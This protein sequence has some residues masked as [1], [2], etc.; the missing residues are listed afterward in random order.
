M[1]LLNLRLVFN[2]F[3]NEITIKNNQ[4]ICTSMYYV[5][6][7]EWRGIFA[8]VVNFLWLFKIFHILLFSMLID[9]H[10]MKKW[11]KKGTRYMGCKDIF[12]S[13]IKNE[14]IIT[15]GA[16]PPWQWRMSIAPRSSFQLVWMHSGPV[17]KDW[18]NFMIEKFYYKIMYKFHSTLER[19]KICL[20]KI[21]SR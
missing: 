21:F 8:Q 4:N 19:W 7:R 13:A 1:F 20:W 15:G 18:N 11:S 17:P 12:E 9:E 2:A 3:C 14:K 16:T 6:N 5:I 10:L